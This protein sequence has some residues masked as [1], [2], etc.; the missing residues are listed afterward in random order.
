M[1]GLGG[2]PGGFEVSVV[3]CRCAALVAHRRSA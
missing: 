2:E 3:G 1:D